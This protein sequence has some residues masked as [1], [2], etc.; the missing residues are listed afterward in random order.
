MHSVI[1]CQ[2]GRFIPC[3]C[4]L[5]SDVVIEEAVRDAKRTRRFGSESRF[6]SDVSAVRATESASDGEAD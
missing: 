1:G 5:A 6:G 3:P 4:A 2:A